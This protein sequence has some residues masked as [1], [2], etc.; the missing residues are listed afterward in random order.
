MKR[1]KTI[2]LPGLLPLCK[3]DHEHDATDESNGTKD[4]ADDD[5]PDCVI[6]HVAA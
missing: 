3:H 4:N 1:W 6:V 2:V 5:G